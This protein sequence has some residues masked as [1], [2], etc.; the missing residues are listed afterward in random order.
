M[1]NVITCIAAVAMLAATVGCQCAGGGCKTG[2]AT[3]QCAG[4]CKGGCETGKCRGGCRSA[5]GNGR[6]RGGCNSGCG[7]NSILGRLG[8]NPNLSPLIQSHQPQGDAGAMAGAV[9]Y[10]YYTVRG[11]RDYFINNPPTIGR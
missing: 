3:S 5:C 11:P 2:C 8:H 9:T 1:K 6:C 10:P 4:G 7:S